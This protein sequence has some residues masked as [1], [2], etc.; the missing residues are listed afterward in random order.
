MSTALELSRIWRQIPK[1]E[2][3]KQANHMLKSAKKY[4]IHEV[5]KLV[6]FNLGNDNFEVINRETLVVKFFDTE[7]QSI[8]FC[9][10]VYPESFFNEQ[11]NIFQ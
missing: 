2:R 7:K 8:D 6:V 9:L 3:D 1:K 4:I 5:N 10:D 11:L